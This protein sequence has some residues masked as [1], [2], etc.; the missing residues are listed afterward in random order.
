MESEMKEK[1]LVVDDE[2]SHRTMLKAVL[3]KEGYDI[4][5]ADD[6]VSAIKAVEN[7][8]FDL[9]LMDIRMGDMDGIEA[10]REIKRISPSI[11]VVMMTA[12]ASVKTAV[13]ALKSDAFDYLTK[14]LDV[15]EL[16]ILIQKALEHYRLHEENVF[17][18]ERL[19]DRFD[20]SKV[21][22]KSRP[23]RDLFETLSLIS[24]S[25]ATVLIYGES[26]TGKE[27][28]ANAIHQN[29]PRSEKPFIKVSCAALP[30]TLLESELFGHERGAFT[31][32]F[33]RKAGRFQL[34]NGG[35]F[36]LDEVSEMSSATQVKLLRVLQ[37]RE[38]E[39]L[40]GT[41][42]IQVDIRLITATN[43]DLE[44]EVKEGRVREDLF[45]RLNVIPIRLPT[46]RERREDIPLLAEHFFKHY[47]D[48]NKSS[49]KGFLPKTID[50]IVRHDWPGNIRELEN[51][52]ER[53]IL[54]CRSEYIMPEDLPSNVQ[55][56]QDGVQPI[57]PVP[58]GMPLKDVEREV[59]L[60][61]LADTAGNRTQTARILGISRKTLQN[62]IKEYGIAGGM[63]G[64]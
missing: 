32:A 6:G 13:E 18:K 45:Y 29:S 54:L 50:T 28:V 37:E 44:T 12:Y 11:P 2:Q 16:K 60:Q 48:K 25:D 46:L 63:K 3:S 57:V 52:I 31:G 17:L 41:K 53:A 47:K 22:G 30:E 7:E 5:E 9:I 51:T 40:G 36:F 19:A 58:S 39:P 55:G 33:T 49:V 56:A 4:S 23:M 14:P 26:G 64:V 62:K 42:T 21:I 15:E 10:M 1:I 20:F 43:K 59:I 38:F 61:T 35:T 8:P 27:L 34:A 24:P